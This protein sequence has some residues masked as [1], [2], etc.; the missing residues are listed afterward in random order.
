MAGNAA[1][2]LLS[3]PSSIDFCEENFAVSESIAEFWGAFSSLIITVFGVIGIVYSNRKCTNEWRFSIAFGVLAAVGIGSFFLHASLYA[4]AQAMDE[5]PMLYEN[6]SLLY[7]LLDPRPDQRQRLITVLLAVA[8]VQTVIYFYLRALYWVFL[9][10]Y[11]SLVVVIVLWLGYLA[12]KPKRDPVAEY[13]RT[14]A[15]LPFFKLALGCYVLI[16]AVVWVIDMNFCDH[17]QHLQLHTVWHIAAGFGTYCAIETLAAH[18]MIMRHTKATLE[19]NLA[20]LT[21]YV[22]PLKMK[23]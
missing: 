16:G 18:R 22:K 20:L 5:V 10:S 11:I 14:H 4:W 6:L 23:E 7:I 8:A 19:W 2:G 1:Q 13:T 3:V 12:Y 21:P 9:V 15:V 17:V